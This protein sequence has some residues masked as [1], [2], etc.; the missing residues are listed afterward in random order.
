MRSGGT[1]S[2]REEEEDGMEGQET[3]EEA[4]KVEVER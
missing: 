4:G 2:G 3:D 1:V